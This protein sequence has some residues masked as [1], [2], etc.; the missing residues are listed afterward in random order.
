MSRMPIKF[1]NVLLVLLA[2][3]LF[4]GSKFDQG[5]LRVAVFPLPP[6]NFIDSDGTAQG[7]FPDL[8]RALVEEDNWS[9]EFVPLT[10]GEAMQALQ[11]EQIDLITTVA[12]TQER[13]KSMDFSK[14]AITDI[15]GQIFTA[16]GSGV[17]NMK[18][19]DQKRVGT[20]AR[21]VN[22]Q[23]FIQVSNNLGVDPII[24]EYKTHAEIF[25]AVQSGVIL[26]GVAPQHYG[27]RH[28]S[29]Y[30][31]VST[32]IM[33]SP[34]S[35]YFAAKK[36]RNKALLAHIDEHFRKWKADSES[37]YYKRLD[38]WMG[39]VNESADVSRW[40]IWIVILGSATS[41]VLI[42]LN[43]YLNYQMNVRTHEIERKEKQYRDLVESANSVILRVN[44]SGQLTF[45]NR[46][47]IDLFGYSSEELLGS[48]LTENL[49]PEI[50]Y[51]GED[52][53]SSMKL[54]MANN[55][56]YKLLENRIHC[57]GGHYLNMQWSNKTIY[58]NEGKPQEVLAIGTDITDKK[59]AEAEISRS[60][61]LINAMLDGIPDALLAVDTSDRIVSVNQSFISIL[62]W[63][64]DEIIGDNPSILF[65]DTPDFTRQ[66]W[67]SPL[68]ADIQSPHIQQYR[69]KNGETF[70]GETISV[71]LFDDDGEQMG[72]ISLITDVTEKQ[73]LEEQVRQSQKLE[74]LG[75]MVGGIAHDF[76]NILQ[77]IMLSG[78]T[79]L[80]FSRE[81]PEIETSIKEILKDSQR[82][83]RLIQQV[84]T[85]GR[86][87]EVKL[88]P[89]YIQ[90][91]IREALD[92]ERANFPRTI[93]IIEAVDQNSPAV[94][95]DEIQMHQAIIN[96]CNNAMHAIGNNKGHLKVELKP[97]GD[98]TP[99]SITKAL[100][101]SRSYVELHISDSGCG[102]DEEILTKIFDPFFSTKGVGEGT[103]L[104]LS[105]VHSI[106]KNIEAP[107]N[108]KSQPGSGT[109]F[110]LWLPTTD[111]I[112]MGRDE[113]ESKQETKMSQPVL[114]VDD[115]VSIRNALSR[116]LVKRGFTVDIAENGVMALELFN[117]NPDKYG[118]ILTDLNMPKMTGVAL[119]QAI[120]GF[121]S[122]VPIVLSSGD[123]S[124]EEM[125]DYKA[126]GIN[127]FIQ[128][129]WSVEGL[130]SYI[131]K[132]DT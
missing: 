81:T 46:Y 4:M 126:K 31:L 30:G 25:A 104:G 7:L 66:E 61:I 113:I 120:R 89:V 107:M 94:L 92:F 100:S 35:V 124:V 48:Q 127:G 13:T 62:G 105:V 112:P 80:S 83:K 109:T 6:L 106:M 121:G 75:I 42:V 54:I 67:I 116:I 17:Q 39:G 86:K 59:I 33:F 64:Q 98:D 28:A 118:L 58:N 73:S 131:A 49:L 34:F 79:A 85:F 29:D 12:F 43:R 22:G 96:I 70:P 56:I 21:G 102:M 122:K 119:A 27:L 2:S 117:Q 82:A 3:G 95:C 76:N 103:G 128:K 87:T 90:N 44:P 93:E 18:D 115:E 55:K 38:Y 51:P 60:H 110:S 47:G 10:W 99:T 15:W 65:A 45:I 23:N 101:T 19:L 111:Q 11:D 69:R 53:E 40:L 84:L 63:E 14:E 125:T 37:V 52:L 1:L 129:P 78:E 97:M 57:K 72:Y 9:V 26:A 114:V 74:A 77:S 16:A 5:K 8:V 36:D 32:S 50:R 91:V 24:I 41:V 130:L 71:A 68:K 132:F 88:E 123:L 108:V 20:M